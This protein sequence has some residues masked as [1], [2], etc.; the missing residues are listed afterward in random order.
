M[1]LASL[2]L[3]NGIYEVTVGFV[4]YRWGNQGDKIYSDVSNLLR[5]GQPPIAHSWKDAYNQCL[6]EEL[7]LQTSFASSSYPHRGL[8][9]S[10][11]HN[12][13][14]INAVKGALNSYPNIPSELF[15]CTGII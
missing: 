8:L 14:A 4:T 1:R 13:E 3:L 6:R 10:S 11:R 9:F 2:V 15:N 12:N 5:H 7:S